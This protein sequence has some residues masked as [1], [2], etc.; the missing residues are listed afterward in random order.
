METDKPLPVQLWKLRP[1]R[2][3][4]Q[5]VKRESPELGVSGFFGLPFY[6][7]SFGAHLGLL[8]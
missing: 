8:V 3:I 5:R 6:A 1:R 7:P 2:G 4:G